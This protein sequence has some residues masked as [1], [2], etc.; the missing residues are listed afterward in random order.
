LRADLAEHASGEADIIV[1]A[2][3]AC[4]ET[5]KEED[6]RCLPKSITWP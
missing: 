2:P 4:E 1:P 5:H 3:E 6:E